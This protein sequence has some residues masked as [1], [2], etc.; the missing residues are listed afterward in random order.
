MVL[1]AHAL[2][3]GEDTKQTFDIAAFYNHPDFNP[4]NFDNDIVLVKVKYTNYV[5]V[6]EGGIHCVWYPVLN[7]MGSSLT[8]S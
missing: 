5:C 2:S 1:G 3:Q 8:G 6:G 7:V 4:K